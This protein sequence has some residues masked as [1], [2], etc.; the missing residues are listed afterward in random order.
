M[1][2][3]IAIAV[4]AAAG[5]G[6]AGAQ[7]SRIVRD[8]AAAAEW[9]AKALNSS[10]YRADFSITSLKELDRF[11]DEHSSDGKPKPG[12]LLSEATG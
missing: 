3:R 2:R 7:E 12:G 1:F 10:G 6:A 8:V 9:M 11:F 5:V 4:L